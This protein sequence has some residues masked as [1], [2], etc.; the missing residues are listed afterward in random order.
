[1]DNHGVLFEIDLCSRLL[2]LILDFIIDV[3][4][5][6]VI[7]DFGYILFSLFLDL[8]VLCKGVKNMECDHIF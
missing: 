4:L 8:L 1:M 2:N 3:G 5:N 6:I 7:I